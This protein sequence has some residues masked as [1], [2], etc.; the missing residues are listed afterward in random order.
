MPN[1][2]NLVLIAAVAGVLLAGWYLW[3]PSGKITSLN[4]GNLGQFTAHFDAAAGDER[5]LVLVSPT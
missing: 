1:T 4:E 2:K 5:L 3:G